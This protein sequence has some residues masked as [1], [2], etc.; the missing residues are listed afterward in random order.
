MDLDEIQMRWQVEK[1]FRPARAPEEME[2]LRRQW[3]QAVGRSKAWA[4]PEPRS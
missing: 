1:E 2:K 3:H 4:E